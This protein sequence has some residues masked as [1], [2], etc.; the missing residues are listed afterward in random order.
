MI[1]EITY[2][3]AT[4]ISERIQCWK[5]LKIDD[6]EDKQFLKKWQGR[7]SLLTPADFNTMLKQ[8]SY[9]EHL[10]SRAFLPFT[11]ERAKQL[12]PEIEKSQ[13]FRM[14]Q[15]LFTDEIP[16]KELNL[17]AALRFHLAF[18]EKHIRT[19][20]EKYSEIHIT[21]E[22]ISD[23]VD[24]LRKEFFFISQK[25]LA[26]DVHQMIEEYQLKGESKEAEF[27]SYIKEFLGDKE[28]T[29][30][31]FAEYPTLARL[32]AI[33][34]TFACEVIETFLA[35]LSHSAEQLVELFQVDSP[36]KLTE[37]LVGQ[38]D[39]HE[40]G[41]TVIQ[42]RLGDVPLVFKFK[43]LKIGERF[44]ELLTYVEEIDK[45]ASFYKVQRLVQPD[46]TIE[47][48]V[49]YKECTK[50]NEVVEFYQQYG[51]LLALTYWLGATDL[52]MENVIA[53]GNQPVLIDVETLIR[54]EILHT[55]KNTRQLRIEKNSV[56]VTG[57]I[58]QRKQWKRE[59]ELDALS[60]TK[61]KLPQKVSR[62]KEEYS[63]EIAF[64][65]EEAYMPAAKNIP[66]LN[67]IEVDYHKYR[68]VILS[69]FKEMN[70]LLLKNKAV[71]IKK[72]KELFSGVQIRLIYRDTQDYGNLLNFTLHTD[73]MS[74]YI[75]REKVIENVWAS[76]VVP[77]ALISTEVESL[78]V[79][80]IP[81]F[82]A[83]TSST[84]IYANGQEFRQM[85]KYSPLQETVA[86]ME[87][88]TKTTSQFSY[89]L[90]KESLEMLEYDLQ[91]I[92]I[93]EKNSAVQEPL[94][95]RAA[96]IG[97]KII[98]QL[99]IDTKRQT[100]DWLSILPADDHDV[101][102]SYPGKDLYEGGSGIYLFFVYL[103]HY[104]PKKMY[105]RVIDLLEKEIF[106]SEDTEEVY[107]SAFFSEG[108]RLTIAFYAYRLLGDEKYRQY[109]EDNL[110]VL[111]LNSNSQNNQQSEWIY[112]R[113]SLLAVVAAIYQALKLPLA[114]Q[115]LAKYMYS[116]T[117][118]E[119]TDNGF[120]H[121]YAGVLYGVYQ[122]S[123]VLQDKKAETILLWYKEKFT[124]KLAIEDIKNDSWCRGSLGIRHV[125][126]MLQIDFPIEKMKR[127]PSQNDCL[128]HGAAGN[129]EDYTDNNLLLNKKSFNLK[130]DTESYPISLF[131]G[132]AGIGYQL[133]RI[134]NVYEVPSVLFIQ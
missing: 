130:T 4:T 54:P 126:E 36:F 114:K 23:L 107:E 115:V 79:H 74:N 61:Q 113:S 6:E 85:L 122:A 103:N 100:I 120:A 47:E 108:M 110:E 49:S 2:S 99:A 10:F 68:K 98:E 5:D 59:V 133:L 87:Q 56:L 55:K 125:C 53:H 13:W 24:Q 70:T 90:L 11:E 72:V 28:R 17:S 42:F 30:L 43:E 45:T 58:P 25:T 77:K 91:K 18:Y 63:S 66:A 95:K 62:L 123:R 84:S 9:D 105:Q 94:L 82:T 48:K 129:V 78:L 75:E 7:K 128:C 101:V 29:F 32:L 118:Q 117:C 60:G 12:L 132:L 67:G 134:F 50:E 1:E 14:H 40:R 8:Y 88:I 27:V 131:G 71:F 57:L 106:D 19:L 86:H 16:L 15:Q 35:S 96:D 111:L 116:M 104:V 97:D 65:L 69:A 31:F 64:H 112:G 20:T 89:L 34:L 80:D 39:S 127:L 21:E 73:C 81:F 51:R 52:H 93:P 109:L 119:M 102:V 92:E 41:K 83:N 46:F 121:G 44:N 33:R 3:Y 22:V 37:V 26:W 76:K 124:E 38:G